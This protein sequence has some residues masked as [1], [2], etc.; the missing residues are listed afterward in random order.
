VSEIKSILMKESEIT[1]AI[2]SELKS[3]N[4]FAW[5]HWSGAVSK[6]GISDILGVLPGGRFLAIEVKAN[7]GKLTDHQSQFLD[8][9]SQAGG[10]A[11]VARS[12]EDIRNELE[13]L[14]ILPSQKELF[15]IS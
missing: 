6:K 14:D 5:K 13:K 8:D 15:G 7:S 9:V 4:I 11:F 12:I 1:K 2:L 10:L 3:M